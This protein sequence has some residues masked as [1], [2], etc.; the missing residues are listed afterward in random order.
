MT[1]IWRLT[2]SIDG[3]KKADNNDAIRL[4]AQ[5]VDRLAGQVQALMAHVA[6]MPGADLPALPS[7]KSQGL[8]LA[9]PVAGIGGNSP[10][11]SDSMAH[12]AETMQRLAKEIASA[13]PAE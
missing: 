3:A 1:D 13:R 2:K 6:H 8:K 11:V 4:L 7:V 9:P 10:L 5:A 12:A